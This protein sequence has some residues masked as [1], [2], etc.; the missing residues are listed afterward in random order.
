M[1][2]ELTARD[3]LETVVSSELAQ[4]II[5]QR[6]LLKKPMGPLAGKGFAK[7]LA[8]IPESMREAAIEHWALSGWWGF[9]AEWIMNA[10]NKQAKPRGVMAAA[11]DMVNYGQTNHGINGA[12]DQRVLAKSKH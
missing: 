8:Q 3:W 1:Q 10:L 2:G 9:K 11:L 6:K 12:Y 4:G 7:Q 5:H